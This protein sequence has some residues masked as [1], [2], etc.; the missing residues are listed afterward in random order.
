MKWTYIFFSFIFAFTPKPA[1]AGIWDSVKN[2]AYQASTLA[3]PTLDRVKESWAYKKITEN[4]LVSCAAA[5]SAAGIINHIWPKNIP[6]EIK[7]EIIKRECSNL[8]NYAYKL[9]TPWLYPWLVYAEPDI[10]TKSYKG[11]LYSVAVT[12][13][14]YPARLAAQIVFN[15]SNN[16]A[17]DYTTLA[18]ERLNE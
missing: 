13:Q 3:Q 5:L 12:A 15:T 4:K 17:R 8:K 18:I 11:I 7:E 10:A 14:E 16:R 1:Q 6:C 9:E 2:Y